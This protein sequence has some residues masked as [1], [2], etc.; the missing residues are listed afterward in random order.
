MRRSGAGLCLSLGLWLGLAPAAAAQEQSDP[1]HANDLYQ[2]A[3]QSIAEGRK[4]DASEALQRVIDK[5]PLHAGA[6]L[7]LALIQCGL[8]H[9]DQAERLFAI[10]EQRF[11]PPPGLRALIA[12]ARAGGCQS[13]TPLSQYSL[14]V[15]RGIDQNVNQGSNRRGTGLSAQEVDT[16]YDLAP[17]FRPKHDQY[18]M[19]SGEYVRDLTPNGTIGFVQFQGRRNDH[20]SQY[21]SSSLFAGTET[22]WRFGNWTVRG[23]TLVG[24]ITLG[25]Q[26]YQRQ[27]QLQARIGPPLPLPF[28][29]QFN[30]VTSVSRLQYLT[31]DNFDANNGELRA[32]FT[33][34]NG[35]SV[36]SASVGTLQDRAVGDRPGGDRHGVAASAQWRHRYDN[37][38]TADLGYNWQRWRGSEVYSPGIIDQVR[39]QNTH[40][41][42]ATFSYPLTKNQ[43]VQLELRQVLNRENISVFQYDNRQLQL[44]WQWQG[45]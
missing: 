42:R 37:A 44:S 7:D 1:S 31:L 21:D 24:L 15:G 18:S 30:L 13:W 16:G 38:L 39:N 45:P 28:G 22:P 43:S 3:L 33:R 2:E 27:V 5:E 19:L 34:R 12:E 8:G 6:W 20:L 9:L 35:D 29:V 32:Q 41:L 36:L 40:T 14:T 25:G 26:L 23:S 17:E 11:A 4:N 10:I